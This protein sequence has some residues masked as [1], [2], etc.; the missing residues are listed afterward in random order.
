[1]AAYP[2]PGVDTQALG[3]NRFEG[4]KIPNTARRGGSLEELMLGREVVDRKTVGSLELTLLGVC[5]S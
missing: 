3:R 5:S 1:M 4:C 2:S